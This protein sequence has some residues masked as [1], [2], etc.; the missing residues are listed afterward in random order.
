MDKPIFRS[1]LFALLESYAPALLSGPATRVPYGKA[2]KLA[3]GQ[4]GVFGVLG[5]NDWFADSDYRQIRADVERLKNDPNIKSI[6]LVIDSPG[7]SVTGLPETGDVIARANRVKPVRAFVTGIAA[8][9]AYWLASQASTIRVTPSV[10]VGSIGVLDL[11]ADVSKALDIAGVKLTAI[12]AGEHKIERAPFSP[13]SD[14]A[15]AEMQRGVDSWYGDFLAAVRR[16]R[17]ARVSQTANYGGGRMLS[18]KDALATGLVDFIN[19]G[20]L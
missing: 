8:S 9:A 7:G 6:D 20:A 17:G 4:I 16:G 3:A 11:H 14:G 15:R 5:Q 19:G 12:H 13:L 18:A 2:P 10:E 1:S